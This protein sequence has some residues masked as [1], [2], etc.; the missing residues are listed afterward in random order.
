M[1]YCDC[2]THQQRQSDQYESGVA[3]A[4]CRQLLA[5]LKGNLSQ[6]PQE[7]REDRV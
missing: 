1:N 2:T 6:T 5:N 7:E 4:R 3:A